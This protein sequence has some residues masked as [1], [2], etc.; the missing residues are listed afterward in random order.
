MLRPRP[1]FDQENDVHDGHR[2]CHEAEGDSAR[3]REV[4]ARRSH[5]LDYPAWVDWPGDSQAV[6]LLR[7]FSEPGSAAAQGLARAQE[8]DDDAAV[9]GWRDEHFAVL[10]LLDSCDSRVLVR[11]LGCRDVAGV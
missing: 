6:G 9:R 5:Y 8:R 10:L 2:G 4:R 7:A 3:V 1:V 11:V